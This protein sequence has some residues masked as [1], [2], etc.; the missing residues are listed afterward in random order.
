[1][2]VVY[3]Y[4]S[5]RISGGGATGSDR[6]RNCKRR[7]T[8]DHKWRHNRIMFFGCLSFSRIFF[9][10]NCT[11]ATGNEQTVTWPRRGFPLGEVCACAIESGVIFALVRS[12]HWEWRHQTSRDP[13]GISLE[14]WVRAWATGNCA[15]SDQT[16]PVG[17]PLENM[18]AC[19]RNRKCTLGAL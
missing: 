13:D 3:Q 12:V 19:I 11:K 8:R 2:T 15:I 17:L 14:G 16:S 5:T 1:M 4:R 18:A 10:P 7:P 9:L 6:M